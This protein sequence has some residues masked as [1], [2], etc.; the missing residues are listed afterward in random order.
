M[1]AAPLIGAGLGAA[2]GGAGLLG[3][4]VGTIGGA[5]GGAALGGLAG[6][7]EKRMSSP[8]GGFATMPPEMQEAY[9]REYLP[10]VKRIYNMGKFTAA[11]M[12]TYNE[13]GPYSSQ[14][15][16]ELQNYSNGIG[17]IFAGTQGV[18]PL[19]TVEPLNDIQ[20][21]ALGGYAG[22]INAFQNELPQ[23]MN[24]YNQAVLNQSLGRLNEEYNGY[25]NQLMGSAARNGLGAFGGSAL[26]TMM[27][28]LQKDREN[29]AADMIASMNLQNYGQAQTLRR[30]TLAE[31]LAAGGAVQEQNQ[32]YLNAL[33]GPLAGSTPMSRV[34]QFGQL[35]GGIPASSTLDY[36][37]RPDLSTRLG[38]ASL[39]MLGMG[40]GGG[41]FGGGGGMAGGGGG[42]P[43]YQPQFGNAFGGPMQFNGFRR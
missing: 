34:S 27:A 10:E 20:K 30:Q 36:Y 23:Y 13:T 8:T 39:A 37:T 2:A 18:K 40:S 35:L 11:P 15:L 14:G 16:Q 6:G 42:F 26:G 33:A 22:G 25:N 9:L 5:L 43:T 38:G 41:L 17:G 31:M 19:G 21:Q 32:Q 12:G 7:K 28:Q 24:P 3:A 1:P 4:S 29:R